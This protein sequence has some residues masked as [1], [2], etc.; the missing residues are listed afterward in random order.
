MAPGLRGRSATGP[1]R[2][3]AVC[4]RPR[5]AKP[6]CHHDEGGRHAAIGPSS[7]YAKGSAKRRLTRVVAYPGVEWRATKGANAPLQV[8]RHART[9]PPIP[10]PPHACNTRRGRHPN[11]APPNQATPCRPVSP[12]LYVP[13][14]EPPLWSKPSE[15]AGGV[16]NIAFGVEDRPLASFAAEPDDSI[17]PN[18]WSAPACPTPSLPARGGGKSGGR[19]GGYVG[20]PATSV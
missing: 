10:A 7:T 2:H 9:R 11:Q 8:H 12:W 15:R 18:A 19:A 17:V 1:G 5:G 14:S 13:G 4:R 6:I 3:Q 20:P 16:V